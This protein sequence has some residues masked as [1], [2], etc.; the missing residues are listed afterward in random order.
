ME[1]TRD[2]FSAL[3]RSASVRSS[4]SGDG[5]DHDRTIVQLAHRR[6]EFKKSI[7]ENKDKAQHLYFPKF[8]AH[9]RRDGNT[10]GKLDASFCRA[11]LRSAC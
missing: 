1:E 7:H 4:G 10:T 2:A 5:T 11:E 6:S 9:R 3:L 8:Q